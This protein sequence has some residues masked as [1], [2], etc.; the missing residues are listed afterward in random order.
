MRRSAQQP[1]PCRFANLPQVHPIALEPACARSHPGE[2]HGP[3]PSAMDRQRDC[4]WRS[5]GLAFMFSPGCRTELTRAGYLRSVAMAVLTPDLAV[6]GA[7]SGGLSVA[8]GAVQMGA[9]VV[10]VERGRMGGDCLNYGCVPSKSLLAAAHA[11]H[12][13]RTAGR[14]GVN[15]HEP[16]VDFLKVREHV[17]GVI[18]GIAPHDSVERLEGLGVTVIKAEA[19]FTGDGIE[20]E[21]DG[22]RIR[23]R[24]AV[25]ATGSR[26]SV[27][28]VPGLAEAPHLTNET[29]FDLAERP[30]HLVVVGGG[31]IGSELAQ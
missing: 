13:V 26:P 11:A 7:G 16:E 10:L 29:I 3:C 9:S 14:F 15:G 24:R 6:I 17:R 30:E 1:E 21:A 27:P 20:I 18:A 28:P 23:P 5:T 12:T 31:P 19:R 2:H 22:T 25:L 8:A 4:Y